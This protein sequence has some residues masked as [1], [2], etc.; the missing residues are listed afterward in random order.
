MSRRLKAKSIEKRPNFDPFLP[1]RISFFI[2]VFAQKIDVK[3]ILWTWIQFS[4]SYC[5]SWYVLARVLIYHWI[6]LFCDNDFSRISIE[7][8]TDVK[9]RSNAIRGVKRNRF[10]DP[11][12]NQ[13]SHF[14]FVFVVFMQVR[15]YTPRDHTGIPVHWQRHASSA[16]TSQW[17][18][19]I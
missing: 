3:T 16:H 2:H 15:P 12:L 18:V 9:D 17:C 6:N 10:F 14:D 7:Q 19:V 1:M 13:T 11:S 5:I 4:S 8:M